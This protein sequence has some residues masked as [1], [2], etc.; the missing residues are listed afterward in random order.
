MS[1]TANFIA[2]GQNELKLWSGYSRRKAQGMELPTPIRNL[3][4][5]LMAKSSLAN[6]DPHM[7]DMPEH[8]MKDE[9]NQS[10]SRSSS[11]ISEET[12]TGGLAQSA[13]GPIRI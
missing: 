4:L 6:G 5:R 1:P 10:V 9:P 3:M 13:V 11:L 7:I 2:V 12:L 8:K